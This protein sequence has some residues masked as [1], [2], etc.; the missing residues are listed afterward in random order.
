MGR[1]YVGTQGCNSFGKDP[2]S[3]SSLGWVE[4]FEGSLGFRDEGI[5]HVYL[6]VCMEIGSELIVC[7]IENLQCFVG[8]W[9]EGSVDVVYASP[10]E[11][12]KIL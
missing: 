11:V 1:D 10:I 5:C 8:D 7:T 6:W 9:L 3:A 4:G 12:D 2:I